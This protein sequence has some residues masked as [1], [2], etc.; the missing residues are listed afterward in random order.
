MWAIAD[1][2]L[3]GA[4][5]KPMDVFGPL[6]VDHVQRMAEAWGVKELPAEVGLTV[7]KMMVALLKRAP[8]SPNTR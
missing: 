1:L 7:T 3:S 2:H 5:P 4:H 6:W 8:S